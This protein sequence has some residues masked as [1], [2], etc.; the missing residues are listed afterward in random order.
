MQFESLN[1]DCMVVRAIDPM[2]SAP[3]DALAIAVLVGSHHEAQA[4][5]D[6]GGDPRP[7]DV[8]GCNIIRHFLYYIKCEENECTLSKSLPPRVPT[9]GKI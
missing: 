2:V 7:G 8:R 4:R 1:V 3:G 9:T 5:D 6:L